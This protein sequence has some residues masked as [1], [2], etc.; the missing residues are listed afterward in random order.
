TMATLVNPVVKVAVGLS[1]LGVAVMWAKQI[2]SPDR[3]ENEHES[4]APGKD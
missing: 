3:E 4:S 2:F 1:A